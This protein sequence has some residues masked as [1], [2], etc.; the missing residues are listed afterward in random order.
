[1]D[2]SRAGATS[3]ALVVA[4]DVPG[5]RSGPVRHPSARGERTPLHRESFAL[6]MM[7]KARRY[8]LS[9]VV[10]QRLV[11]DPPTSYPLTVQVGHVILDRSNISTTGQAGPAARRR[12]DREFVAV[13]DQP[14]FRNRTAE[15]QLLSGPVD[16]AAL[17]SAETTLRRR[18]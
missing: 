9:S 12:D 6:L 17:E 10:D 3:D 5:T 13:A 11:T 7:A 4:P 16:S 1:M 2:R 8:D 14:A 15:P 18:S